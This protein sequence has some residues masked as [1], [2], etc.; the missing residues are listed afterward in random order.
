MT[1]QMENLPLRI[2]AGAHYAVEFHE[3]IPERF[4]RKTKYGEEYELYYHDIARRT[5]VVPRNCAPPIQDETVAEDVY[6]FSMGPRTYQWENGF[7]PRSDEQQRLV[8]ESVY[9]LLSGD[10]L[11]HIIEAPTGFGKTW[12]GSAVIQQVGVRACVITT[13]EDILEEWQKTLAACLNIDVEDVGIWRGDQVPEKHHQV[14]VALVQSVCKGYERYDPKIY[15]GFGLVMVDEVH[16]MG[17]DEFSKAMWH[18]PARFRVGLSATPYRKDGREEVFEAHIG[19][20][21]TRTDQVTMGFKVI[22]VD[23]EWE[24]PVVWNWKKKKK[25]KLD[26][27]WDRMITAVKY[28]AT[29]EHRN[30]IIVR[31]LEAAVKKG[32]HTVVFSDTVDHL[33][34]IKEACVASGMEDTDEMFGFY[35]GLQASVYKGGAEKRKALREKA[36]QALVCL[37]TYKMCSEATNVPWWS[38]GVLATPKADVVQPVGRVLREYPDKPQPVILDLCDY[39]HVVTATF[40]KKRREWYEEQGADIVRR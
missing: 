4:T 16:R 19:R 27:P 40:A 34:A 26:I 23:T 9:H 33:V 24:V 11:G 28:L 5:Y 31:F 38:A 32:R 29:D 1:L 17:A 15:E 7:V 35:C 6:A 3:D 30:D 39:N 12:V 25:T 18:F 13:K 14:V 20:V 22:C 8:N 37:A 2:E 36:K 10:S 21:V